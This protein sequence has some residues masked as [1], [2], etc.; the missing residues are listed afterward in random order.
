M[1]FDFSNFLLPYFRGFMSNS[2]FYVLLIN[3]VLICMLFAINRRDVTAPFKKIRKHAWLVFIIILILGSYMRFSSPGCSNQTGVCFNYVKTAT[4]MLENQYVRDLGHPKAYSLL[5]AIGFFFFGQNYSVVYYFNL[6]MSSLTILMVFL[7]AYVL[8][9]REDAAL[10]SALVYSLFPMPIIFAKLNA[11][12]VTAVFFFTLTVLV[13]LISLDLNKRNMYI[14]FALLAVFSLS[15]RTD[16]TTFFL[17]FA[18]GFFLNRRK[19]KLKELRIPIAVFLLFMIPASYYY[20]VGYDIYGPLRDPHYN[21]RPYVASPA[22]IVTN[23]QK[24]LSD[25]LTASKFYPPILYFFL[26]F[27]LLFLRKERGV[28][29]LSLLAAGF[30]L[31]FGLWWMTIYNST[32]LYQLQLQPTLAVLM[33]YGI[34]RAKDHIDGI[35]ENR[36]LLKITPAIRY[37]GILVTLFLIALVFQAYTNVFAPKAGNDCLIESIIYLGNKY[38]GDNDCLLFENTH[39]DVFNAFP[40]DAMKILLPDK[41]IST[42][43]LAACG[44]KQAFYLSVDQTICP[45]TLF[46]FEKP[47]LKTLENKYAMKVL[48]KKGCITLYKIEGNETAN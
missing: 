48:E 30:F 40:V 33:G 31:F 37:S 12:E 36:G 42:S 16:A 41:N 21:E 24:H 15:V 9:K 34:A 2:L 26:L 44:N 25:N 46:G 1:I 4:E 22:Y 39:S 19:L 18:A 27:S 20:M 43:S 8:F 23:V 7:L 13:Y 38:I 5:M 45:H 6:V 17:L 47:V 28:L 11:S 3:F 35:V 14:L 10:F 29:Y 32:Q